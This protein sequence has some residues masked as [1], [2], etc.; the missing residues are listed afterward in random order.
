MRLIDQLRSFSRRVRSRI[1]QTLTG[2]QSKP[3]GEPKLVEGGIALDQEQEEKAVLVMEIH[4]ERAEEL[5]IPGTGETVASYNP[6]YPAD[7]RVIE[8]RFV[9]TLNAYLS[10]WTTTDVLAANIDGTLDAG[11]PYFYPESR[12]EP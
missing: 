9:E 8:V 1:D 4:D 2:P 3:E 12:L 7:D 6:E 5:T 11:S 10:E